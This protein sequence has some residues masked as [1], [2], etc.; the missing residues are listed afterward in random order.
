MK[1]SRVSRAI[2][3]LTALQSGQR[4]TVDGLA[5]ML[6]LSK[7]TVFRDLEV[8]RRAGVPCDYEKKTRGY[9]IDPKFFLP[10]PNLT[11]Q[12]ALALLLLVYKARNHIHLPF[13]SSVL[14][15]ALKIESNLPGEIKRFCN[16]ALQNISIKG[17]PQARTNLL[18]KIFA[19]LLEAI[20]K[21]QVVNIRYYLPSE[22]KSTVTNLSPYH[23]MY[24]DG[25]WY[26][27][28]KPD[29]HKG[30]GTFKLSQIE[31]LNT[32]DECFIEDEKFDVSEYLGRAWSMMPEGTLYHVKLKFLPE[33]ARSI[34]E[35]QWHSTQTVTFEDDGSAIVEFRV[36]G[37][38]EITWWI[39][40]YGDQVQVLAPKILR[41]RII[42]IAQDMVKRNEQLLP[43]Y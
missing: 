23:L 7:R 37:L 10:A 3:I 19:Q 24:N 11:T 27:L 34:G 29:L 31:E 12:E 21:K 15:A 13:M 4:Y 32:L 33:V 16:T 20:L 8:L 38:N 41:Q 18:D 36:D 25:T 43:I 1:T 39:L 14:R 30:V 26:V 28:G 35:V 9:T 40:S 2:Q 42:R 6:G 17:D 5:K 22:Q